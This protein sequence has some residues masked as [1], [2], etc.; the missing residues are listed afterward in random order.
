MATGPRIADEDQRSMTR[1]LEAN[2]GRTHEVK[3][4]RQPVRVVVIR[5]TRRGTHQMAATVM[6]REIMN[7]DRITHGEI[8]MTSVTMHEVMSQD[9]ILAT[10]DV[11]RAVRAIGTPHCSQNRETIIEIIMGGISINQKV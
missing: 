9:T 7:M 4:G 1:T 11:Q 5:T 8:L 2:T 3:A 10:K 6:P